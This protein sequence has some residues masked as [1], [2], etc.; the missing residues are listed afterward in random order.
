MH[1]EI[2]NLDAA[3]IR[4][5]MMALL[6]QQLEALDSPGGLTD[7]R[8]MECYERQHRVQM[9]REKLQFTT[10]QDDALHNEALQTEMPSAVLG[11]SRMTPQSPNA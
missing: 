2:E 9:L 8:L 4:R 11:E 3:A 6:R 7:A 1:E 10:R 5:E